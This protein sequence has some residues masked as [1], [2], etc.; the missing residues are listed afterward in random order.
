MF[1]YLYMIYSR[2][3]MC[4]QWQMMYWGTQCPVLCSG[5]RKLMEFEVLWL[6]SVCFWLCDVM[7][8]GCV[9]SCFGCIVWCVLIVLWCDSVVWCHW[10]V[11]CFCCK[12][13]LW[14]CCGVLVVCAV[15]RLSGLGMW[16]AVVQCWEEMWMADVLYDTLCGVLLSYLL[17]LLLC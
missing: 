10:I 17:L 5:P 2:T 15:L 3:A 14:H 6:G 4:V 1:L 7:C 13:V 12:G 8:F 16:S 9:T 11:W